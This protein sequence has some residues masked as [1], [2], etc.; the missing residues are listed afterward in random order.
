ML[1]SGLGNTNVE[2]WERG[3]LGN[4]DEGVGLL[5]IAI[6]NHHTFWKLGTLRDNGIYGMS[7]P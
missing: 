2:A 7:A 4:D 1:K 3:E 6:D 5:L